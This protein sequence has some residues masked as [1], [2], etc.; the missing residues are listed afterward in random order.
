MIQA[1]NMNTW[2]IHVTGIVQGVG[3][4]PY[5]YKLATK[6]KVNGWVKNDVDGVRIMITCD[7][8]V[9]EQFYHAIKTTPPQRAVIYSTDIASK[10]YHE[11]HDFRIIQDAEGEN[12]TV[13]L[14]PDFATCERCTS[15]LL[16]PENIRY[17]YPF[18]TCSDCGPR[19]SITRTIPFERAHTE[20]SGFKMCKNCQREYHKLPHAVPVG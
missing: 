10:P 13:Q 20:M 9:A 14:T 18:I 2:Y 1:N 15:E 5:V 12:T 3:F 8:R 11:F 16:D 17:K 6:A 4:R 7:K 19:Y